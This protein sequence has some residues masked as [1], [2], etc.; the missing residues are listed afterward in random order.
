ML[1]AY[2]LCVLSMSSSPLGNQAPLTGHSLLVNKHLKV[3]AE[4][5]SPFIL[6][7]CDGKEIDY[8]QECTDKSSITYG[9]PL[10]ELLQLVKLAKNVT[11]SLF[12]PPDSTWG[13]CYGLNNCTGMI[14]MVNRNEVDFALGMY[15]L[16]IQY[17]GIK[18]N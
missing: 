12:R 8:S 1:M 11:F 6:F 4:P 3:A 17:T 10:W 5:W 13:F 14:G 15:L 7:Y 16:Q 9:G 2:F 18:I